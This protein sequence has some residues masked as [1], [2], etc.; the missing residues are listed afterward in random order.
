[1]NDVRSTRGES[2]FVRTGL[3]LLASCSQAVMNVP[4]ASSDLNYLLAKTGTWVR[5]CGHKFSEYM[6]SMQIRKV[7]RILL[8]VGIGLLAVWTIARFHKVVG[9]RAAIARF[10]NKAMGLGNAAS[11]FLDPNLGA[12]VDF[13]LWSPGRISAYKESLEEKDDAPLAILRIPKIHLEVPVFNDTD[14]LT[15]N[16][17]VGRI[18]GT[19]QIGKPGN[20]GIAGHR[21]GFFRGLQN[22]VAGDRIEIVEPYKTDSYV[23]SEIQIVMPEDIHVLDP[24]PRPTLTL[25]TCFP[26]YFVGHAPKR[27]IVTAVLASTDQPDLGDGRVGI[28]QGKNATKKETKR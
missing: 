2:S 1:M 11:P 18:L 26:F 17:G 24:T 16:R 21:D 5:T 23:V 14:D 8:I 28:S 13:S 19:A 15:L 4:V 20:L 22:V 25:V 3:A 7:E 6:R 9:S 27:Y 12:P 10:E